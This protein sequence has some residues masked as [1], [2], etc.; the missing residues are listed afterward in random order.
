MHP[1]KRP[2]A[3]FFVP[4]PIPSPTP[5]DLA[6]DRCLPLS[7]CSLQADVIRAAGLSAAAG[8]WSEHTQQAVNVI[9]GVQP[10]NISSSLYPDTDVQH[11]QHQQRDSLPDLLNS[12]HQQQQQDTVVLIPDLPVSHWSPQLP[13][14]TPPL[15]NDTAAAV[16]TQPTPA[17]AAA[18]AV[19]F[20]SPGV[21]SSG[22]HSTDA[23]ALVVTRPAEGAC[24]TRV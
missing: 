17:A 9:S 21:S 13:V 16:P 12:H 18:A 23:V 20:G 4:T 7:N 1:G 8:D 22:G 5:S 11:Q 19:A 6:P 3:S 2:V 15:A 10:H 14:S 24:T